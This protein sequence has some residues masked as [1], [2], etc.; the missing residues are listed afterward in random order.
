[1]SFCSAIWADVRQWSD[2]HPQAS[3]AY[4]LEFARRDREVWIVAGDTTVTDLFVTSSR[5]AILHDFDS[6]LTRVPKT[7]D[8]RDDEGHSGWI[9]YTRLTPPQSREAAETG[10]AAV[11]SPQP[12]N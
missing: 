3:G 5:S 12:Q 11:T 9:T 2:E 7:C 6:R 1:M 10:D 8:E 4:G